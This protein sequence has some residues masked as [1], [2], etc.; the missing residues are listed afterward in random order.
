MFVL[1]K[2]LVVLIATIFFAGLLV[3]TVNAEDRHVGYYY[4]E[5]QTEETYTS[6]A[7]PIPG[8]SRRSRTAFV[9]GLDQIQ[10]NRHYAPGYHM[11]AKG[12][13]AEKLIIAATEEGRYNTFFRLR[14]LIA[15]MSSDARTSPLF[16]KLG[17][18]EHLNF[19]DLCRMAGFER[20]TITNGKDIAHRI[21]LKTGK[22]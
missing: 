2:G 14:A 13:H 4:P 20:L 16:A 21:I 7:P 19:L 9:V 6:P 18:V 12:K 1:R 15:S 3:S 22:K 17:N 8:V 10:K 5:P 11:Y